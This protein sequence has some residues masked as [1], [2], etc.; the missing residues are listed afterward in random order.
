MYEGGLLERSGGVYW[1]GMEW[2]MEGSTGEVQRGR[3]ARY[4]GVY[5]RTYHGTHNAGGPL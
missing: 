4:G 2:C 3:L 5:W 1:R